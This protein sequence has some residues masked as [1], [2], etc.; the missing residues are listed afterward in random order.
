[1][2]PRLIRLPD[3]PSSRMPAK[4]ISI[5]RGIAARHDQPGAEV[6]EEQKQDDDDEHRAFEEL[7]S[8]VRIVRSTS[9]LRS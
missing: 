1:M 3:R 5:A 2:A 7:C 6:A 9:A 8:T 4:A